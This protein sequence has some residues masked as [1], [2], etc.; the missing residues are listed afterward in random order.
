MGGGGSAP[1]PDPAIGKSAVMSARTGKKYL[2]WM[3]DRAEI[4]DAWAQEDRL[5][6]KTVFQPMQDRFIKDA[7]TWDTPGRQAAAARSAVADVRSGI[8]LESQRT[9]REMAAMGV[10]PASGRGMAS[11]RR[12]AIERGL[13]VAG[14]ANLARA[15]VRKEGMALRGDA[16]NLGSGLAVN[17]LSSFTAGTSAGAR[18]FEG[19]MQG[20]GQQ[21][22]MLNQSYSNQLQAWSAEQ[23]QG[24]PF[25]EALGMG[26]GFLMSDE[27]VK[28]KKK[29]VRSLMKAVRGMRVENWE[30]KPDAAGGDGGGVE[31][32]GT[33]A[34]DFKAATGKGDGKTI[35]VVDAIGVTMGALKEL[36]RKVE[37]ISRGLAKAKAA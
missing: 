4:T 33:Y 8:A 10:N 27:E 20:Y 22:S 30:Y 23:Q 1:S 15:G 11:R 25:M 3:K 16:I 32:T 36:D 6:D 7:K 28:T 14:A 2:A 31:H 24:N 34:Q 5:R 37:R 9:E 29:P 19:A 12:S 18:G 21:G 26:A 17:P 35:P 13:S